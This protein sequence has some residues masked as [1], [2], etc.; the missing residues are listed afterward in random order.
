M[1]DSALW[2]GFASHSFNDHNRFLENK[3]AKKTVAFQQEILASTKLTEQTI[4]NCLLKL[5][6]FEHKFFSVSTR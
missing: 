6:R 5:I 4:F 1:V 3:K 2:R